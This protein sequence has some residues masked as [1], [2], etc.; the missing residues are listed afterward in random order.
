MCVEKRLCAG[1]KVPSRRKDSNRNLFRALRDTHYYSFILFDI[2]IKT[3][4][5]IKRPIR[6]LN[7]HLKGV[8]RGET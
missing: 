8:D 3:C 2:V 6:T 5:S 7:H 1:T 4:Y